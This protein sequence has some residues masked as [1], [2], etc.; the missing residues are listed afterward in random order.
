MLKLLTTTL[1]L[2][3]FLTGFS[4][5]TMT[6]APSEIQKI[7]SEVVDR[8][9]FFDNP[10]IAAGQLSPDG[11]K[12]SFMKEHDGIM[13]VWVKAIDAKFEEAKLLTASE[14]PIPGYFWTDDSKYILYVNDNK[15]DENFNI[16]AVNPN[17]E[18]SADE[19]AP[20]SKNL[21]PMEEVRIFI[22]QVS[23]KNP[24]ELMVGINDRDKAWHDL[25]KLTIST[26]ELEK[27]LEN[28]NRYTG[29]YFDWEENLRM[30]SRTDEDGNNQ[31]LRLEPDG[32]FE[33]IYST[34]TK[35]TAYVSGWTKDNELCYLVS[36]KGDVNLRTLYTLNPNTGEVVKIESDP[37]NKVD[38]GSLFVNDNT[39]EII[40][41]SYTY[42]KRKRYFKDKKWE[43]NFKYLQKE[44]PGK[45]VGFT[46][47]TKDY[48]K[49]LVVAY[50]DKYASD[51]YYFDPASK[52]LIHQYTPRPRLKEI[53]KHLSAMK[54]I[55]YKSSDGL[56]IPGYLSL[57]SGVEAKNLPTVILPHGGPK[58]PRDTWGYRSIVQFLSSRGYA[59]MQP[60]F[61]ASGGYGKAFMN[62]GDKEWG[63]L[64]QDDITWGVKYLIDE[65]ITDA[66]RVA[67]MGISYGG[68]ATLAGLAYTPDLYACGVDIVGPSNLFTLME[69]IPPYWEAGRIRLYEMVGDPETEEGQKLMREASPLFSADKISKPL[70][71]V[72]GAN[73]PRVK[74]AEADQ[75]VMAL[76]ENGHPVE[77]LLAEDEGHGFRKPLNNMAM[78]A[79]VEQFLSKHIGGNLQKDMPDDVA[80]TLKKLTIDIATVELKEKEDIAVLSE[81]PK[82]TYNWKE[83]K[84][85][86]DML[87]EVQGQKIPM[88]MTRTVSKDGDNW[89]VKEESSSAMGAIVDE[90]TYDANFKVLGRSGEQ[91]GQKY[92]FDYGADNVK[93]KAMGKDMDIKLEDGIAFCDGAG[94]DMMLASLDLKES[95]KI[96]YYVADLA[97]VKA[98]QVVLEHMGTETMDDGEACTIFMI[99]NPENESEM[100]KIWI[101][102]AKKEAV[103]IESVIPAM[104]NAKMTQTRK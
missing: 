34:N 46:S 67:I 61:R 96:S 17:A 89:I 45:E 51:V 71:V 68:Y 101:D 100:T 63:K 98:K 15:G 97:T 38:F 35:E 29:Y 7:K 10:E 36:D 79:R 77:Y 70:L 83:S 85:A 65:G 72:Q 104:G 69:S 91:G 1:S 22:Y 8:A 80:E 84:T 18:V 56:D 93:I 24:D 57:P 2:F 27:L 11:M 66:D 42:D 20:I 16:Y 82:A 6:K 78:Y 19:V 47:F 59:V 60:N 25:Y 94:Y 49:M 88:S 52:E 75:I 48:S 31:I 73:D 95:D 54:P 50:G 102:P 62:A 43:A 64:M 30:A 87:I 99:T 58:G 4:Q 55:S 33:D 41:T 40:A 32:T 86:Y 9:I 13:N 76:R 26:G 5:A 3:L 92:S 44:F 90:T 14:S 28:D 74:K 12:V 39:R 53:E 23:K 21:T 37:E 103:K 81:I